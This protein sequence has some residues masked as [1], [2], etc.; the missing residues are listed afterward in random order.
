MRRD[1]TSADLWRI[2]SRNRYEGCIVS[3]FTGQMGE[4]EWLLEQAATQPWIRGVI[5]APAPGVCAV[6]RRFPEIDE[7]S[8]PI[9]LVIAPEQL[10][11]ART[12]LKGRRVALVNN[13]G[14]A[15]SA[16]EFAVWS[17]GMAALAQEP[18]VLVKVAGLINGAGV[19]RWDARVYRPYIQFLLEAFG[20]ERLMYGS[21]WPQ[22]MQAGTWKESMAA[23]TQA[24]G[25]QT[26]QTR[27]LILG[28]NA[29]RFYGLSGGASH[30][31]S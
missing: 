16:G 17:R 24:L 13:G 25:A 6:R 15:Y 31:R 10:G 30:E 14:A 9:D 22:C 8:G 19:D 23:F 7:V 5:G 3:A 21:D 2:L 1:F 18:Q 29:N 28:A 20:P 12:H 26:Q 11:E 27:D 4:T